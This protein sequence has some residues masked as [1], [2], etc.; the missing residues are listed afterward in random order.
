[1]TNLREGGHISAH[2]YLIGAKVAEVI[3]GGDVDGGTVV[4]E[5]WLLDLERAAFMELIATEKSQARIAHMLETG[6][7]LRN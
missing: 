1:M 5:Q 3:T 4:D 7:P 2:D 6:K